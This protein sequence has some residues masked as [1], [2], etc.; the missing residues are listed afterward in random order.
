MSETTQPLPIHE[1][2][3]ERS[4]SVIDDD[5][6]FVK[7]FVGQIPKDMNEDILLTFFAEFGPVAELTVIRDKVN[8]SHKGCAF[9]TYC[10]QQ[11]ARKAVDQ[12]HDKIKLPNVRDRLCL[13]MFLLD[14]I[15]HGSYVVL[16]VLSYLDIV[17]VVM[18]FVSHAFF[19]HVCS[20][21]DNVGCQSIASTY[22]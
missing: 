22:C 2:P 19:L 21:H 14:H 13:I 9:L 16:D 18:I 12:L 5:A 4:D 15:H 6:D 8:Q 7:L 17:F 20:I 11:S 10:M 1:R 3:N